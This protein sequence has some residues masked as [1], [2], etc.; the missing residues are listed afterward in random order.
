MATRDDS[1]YKYLAILTLL[2]ALHPII[3][4]NVGS[5]V[6]VTYV[7]HILVLMMSDVFR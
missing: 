6:S 2:H 1:E 5:Y 4:R 3:T 7:T